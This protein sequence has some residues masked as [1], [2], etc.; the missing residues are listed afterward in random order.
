[1]RSL[2]LAALAAGCASAAAPAP[3]APYLA[4]TRYVDDAYDVHAVGLDGAPAVKVDDAP[5]VIWVYGSYDGLLL[6][7][8]PAR[9]VDGA[10]YHLFEF[11]PS[12]NA[13]RQVTDLVVYDSWLGRS[14]DGGRYVVSSRQDGRFDLYV[15][16]RATGAHERLTDDAAK[17]TD[18]DWSP[19]GRRILFRSDR[20]GTSD[21]W[22]MDLETRGLSQ[23]TDDPDD[24]IPTARGYGGVGPGRWSPDGARI[25]WMQ[26][27]GDTDF[28]ICVM[29]ADGANKGCLTD[30][31]ES[32]AYPSWSPDGTRIAYD[33]TTDGVRDIWVM[34]ADGSNKRRITSSPD[35]DY[36]ATWVEPTP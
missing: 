24:H 2:P 30:G 20:G 4:F 17:N 21:L 15:V 11:D 13:A 9:D 34:N 33:A 12:T 25:A 5:D 29:D 7:V 14:P 18:P 22:V 1:M 27:N 32:D 28:D 8:A 10:G 6:T 16:D 35:D 31:P 3:D 23:L 19:D 26:H 36:A